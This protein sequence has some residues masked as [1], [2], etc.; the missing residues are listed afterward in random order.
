MSAII[1]KLAIIKIVLI[2][3]LESH[4][5]FWITANSNKIAKSTNNVPI[6][7][8]QIPGLHVDEITV[9]LIYH[10]AAMV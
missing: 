8:Y 10:G 5:C 6:G 9:G 7:V 2:F 1:A 3:Q 4:E